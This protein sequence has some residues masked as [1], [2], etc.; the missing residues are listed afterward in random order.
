MT[1]LDDVV[2]V[3][4]L[5]YREEGENWNA[6]YAPLDT[7][8]GAIYLGSI[9]MRFVEKKKRRRL[10]MDLMWECFADVVQEH[11]GHRP[12]RGPETAAPEHERTKQ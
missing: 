6:Y 8:V 4:R 2:K 3:G 9:K 11:F 5:A 12:S 1:K 7:M 10:F